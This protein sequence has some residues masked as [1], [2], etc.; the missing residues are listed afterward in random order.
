M[1]APKTAP[2]R[3]QVISEITVA[4]GWNL[5]DATALVDA[6]IAEVATPAPLD[7]LREAAQALLDEWDGNYV[8][9]DR[10]AAVETVIE[11]LRAAYADEAE[12]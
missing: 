9:A 12:S 10:M 8:F 7:G 2:L 11:A 6:L 5:T 1:G 4:P 3:E